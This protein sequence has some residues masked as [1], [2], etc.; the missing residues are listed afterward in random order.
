MRT[1]PMLFSRVITIIT[2][3]TIKAI[4]IVLLHVKLSLN[5]QHPMTMAVRGSSAPKIDVSVGPTC[6]IACPKPHD[7]SYNK[8]LLTYNIISRIVLNKK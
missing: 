3:V 6:L 8:N 7:K 2:A 1:L 4:P 5:T